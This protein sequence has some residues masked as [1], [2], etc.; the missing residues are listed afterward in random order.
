M[1]VVGVLLF[2]FDIYTDALVVDALSKTD[3]RDWMTVTLVFILWHY[4]IM[5]VLVTAYLKRTTTKLNVLGLEEGDSAVGGAAVL[6]SRRRHRWLLF[7]PV[8]VPGV[9]LL[10]ITMLFT[11]ILPIAFPRLFVNFSSFLSNY[12]FSRFFIE[13]VF[14]SIPQTILQTYIYHQLAQGSHAAQ[15]NECA[16]RGDTWKLVTR[17]IKRHKKLE[18]V[19]LIQTGVLTKYRNAKRYLAVRMLFKHSL[20][21]KTVALC[22]SWWDEDYLQ[23]AVDMYLLDHPTLES[24]AIELP[25]GAPF[26]LREAGT[27]DPRVGVDNSYRGKPGRR[28]ARRSGYFLG[29]SVGGGGGGTA[30]ALP[31]ARYGVRSRLAE[32]AGAAGVNGVRHG[33]GGQ[34][35]GGGGGGGGTPR[36]RSYFGV[37]GPAAGFLSP[38]ST[39]ASAAGSAAGAAGGSGG[40]AAVL[41]WVQYGGA[42]LSGLASYVTDGAVSTIQGLAAV[43]SGQPWGSAAAGGAAIPGVASPRYC[44]LLASVLASAP[45]LRSLYIHNHALPEAAADGVG[46]LAAALAGNTRLTALSLR[47]SAVG[48]AGAAALARALSGHNSTLQLLNLRRCQLHDEGVSALCACLLENRGLRSL[49]LSHSRS[50]DA[51]VANAALQVVTAVATAA[52]GGSGGGDGGDDLEGRIGDAGVAALGAALARNRSLRELNLAGCRCGELGGT[53]LLEAL[54]V[55]TALQ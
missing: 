16:L 51:G 46:Q 42:V 52:A 44:W 13:F 36:A 35:A 4:V 12:N 55:N 6:G 41:G 9:V 22:L 38:F 18:K 3:H 34:G 50:S 40:T 49:D 8:A 28:A 47:G 21:L 32:A 53:A 10:D 15:V 2:F 45:A 29:G 54:Q 30:A 17:A 25:P 43:A 26:A 1:D 14:E 33:G 37:S 19:K 11:S 39:D 7:V 24:L 27:A 31:T 5:A 48:D 20:G 23:G